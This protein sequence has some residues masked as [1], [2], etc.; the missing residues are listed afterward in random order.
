MILIRKSS[1]REST[2]PI[3][4]MKT[5]AKSAF[6]EVF[7]TP[8]EEKVE[9]LSDTQVMVSFKLAKSDREELD[10]GGR[11][12]YHLTGVV[13]S[14]WVDIVYW[15]SFYFNLFEADEPQFSV[16]V[17]PIVAK[18][19]E[20]YD[21]KF[22]DAMVDHIHWDKEDQTTSEI[23]KLIKT[24]EFSPQKVKTLTDILLVP[25][26]KEEAVKELKL[27]H[28]EA[29]K[30]SDWDPFEREIHEVLHPSY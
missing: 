28:K 30:F 10:N 1:L 26:L 8:V 9:D 5:F 29:Q 4:Q 21:E 13:D 14:T 2:S 24:F 17:F 3:D 18:H 12:E 11:S 16:C 22:F 23:D 20:Y 25:N 7:G 15:A 19:D 6:V 27:R